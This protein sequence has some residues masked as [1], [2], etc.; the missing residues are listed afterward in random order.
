MVVGIISDTHGL[1]RPEALADLRGCNRIIHAGDLGKP[2]IFAQLNEIAPA[3]A[4]RGNVDRGAWADA[5]PETL[6][7]AI[8]GVDFYVLHDL[9]TLDFD[10]ANTGVA[11]VVSGHSHQPIIKE[12]GGVLY[13]NPGSAGP[14]RFSLPI[15]VARVEI[16]LPNL[17]VEIIDILRN[18]I[19][20]TVTMPLRRTSA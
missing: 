5:F 16:S 18:I 19:V 6:T 9:N 2:E 10:P 4:V 17:R 3:V 20:Q 8:G 11:V 1:L 13:L 15:T 7:A 14:R 12:K